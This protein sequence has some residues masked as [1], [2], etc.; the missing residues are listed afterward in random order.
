MLRAR[1]QALIM[2]AAQ[3]WRAL[4]KKFENPKEKGRESHAVPAVLFSLH[5]DRTDRG[6]S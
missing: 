6:E 4:K 5:H 2:T 1:R 3:K